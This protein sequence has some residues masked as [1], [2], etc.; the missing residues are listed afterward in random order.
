MKIALAVVGAFAYAGFLGY[1]AWAV[2][3][4]EWPAPY[5]NETPTLY[6]HSAEDPG[7]ALYTYDA[8]TGIANGA[9][10]VEFVCKGTICKPDEIWCYRCACNGLIQAERDRQ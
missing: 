5:V 2:A 7:P 4:D 3:I 8:D 10:H 1:M 6:I 9:E